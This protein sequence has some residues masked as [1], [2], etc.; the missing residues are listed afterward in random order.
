MGIGH[1]A[2][3]YRNA[4]INLA[5][6]G[7]AWPTDPNSL[8]VKT[9]DAFAQEYARI[10]QLGIYLLD[11]IF[12]DTTTLLLPDWERV[13]GLPDECSQIGETIAVRRLNLLQKITSR[14]G[15]SKAYFIATA[16]SLGYTVTVDEFLPFRVGVS[17]VSDPLCNW[18]WWFTWR[19]N[20][21]L[22]SIIW[23]KASESGAHEPLAYWGNDRLEC[24]MNKL[25]P[26]HTKLL[27]GYS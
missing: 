24:I 18:K 21:A 20:S 8:W 9:L 17:H 23:F 12:P 26:A 27:F 15:Q 6:Q 5:P 7:I 10:D 4:L 19:I 2:D 22:F 25:K 16:L 1:S 14:G 13:A 3:D 11:E